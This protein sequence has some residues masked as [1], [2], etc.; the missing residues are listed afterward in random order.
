MI[1]PIDRYWTTG[2]LLESL[3]ECQRGFEIQ[4]YLYDSLAHTLWVKGLPSWKFALRD[5][6]WDVR[7]VL[8]PEAVGVFISLSTRL[9]LWKRCI[10]NKA[11]IQLVKKPHGIWLLSLT[12]LRIFLLEWILCGKDSWHKDDLLSTGRPGEGTRFWYQHRELYV[13]W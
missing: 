11:E 8:Q 6:A 4:T 3:L 10:S 7:K 1:Y 2:T 9:A 5:W 13:L 12:S